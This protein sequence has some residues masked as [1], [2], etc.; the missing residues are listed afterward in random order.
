MTKKYIVRRI[1]A[2][3]KALLEGRLSR[4]RTAFKDALQTIQLL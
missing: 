1:R 3:D 4:I 2:M